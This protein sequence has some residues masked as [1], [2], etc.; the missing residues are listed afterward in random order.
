MVEGISLCIP[1][2][3]HRNCRKGKKLHF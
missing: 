2:L 1:V 3:Y